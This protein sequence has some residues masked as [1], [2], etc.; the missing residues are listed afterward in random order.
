[1]QQKRLIVIHGAKVNRFRDFSVVC[2][3]SP[4]RMPRRLLYMYGVYTFEVLRYRMHEHG[5]KRTN[6]CKDHTNNY[7]IIFTRRGKYVL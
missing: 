1:M 4:I 3:P 2:S 5:N 7:C 6:P